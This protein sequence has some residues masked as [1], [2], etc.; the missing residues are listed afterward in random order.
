MTTLEK[1]MITAVCVWLAA[2][3]LCFYSLKKAVE[4]AGGLK[5]IA[6][7]IGKEVKD[8]KREIDNYQPKGGE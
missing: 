6:V 3:V 1:K 8:I 4:S 7:E 2:F 5:G